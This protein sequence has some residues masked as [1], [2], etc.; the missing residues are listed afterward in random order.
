MGTA[1]LR[2]RLHHWRR[3]DGTRRAEGPGC[4]YCGHGPHGVGPPEDRTH[5]LLQCPA[6]NGPR[7]MLEN[8]LRDAGVVT[9]ATVQVLL[10]GGGGM[11]GGQRATVASALHEYLVTTG[12]FRWRP[13]RGDAPEWVPEEADGSVG[14]GAV[15]GEADGDDDAADDG[16]G[17]VG[18]AGDAPE[19]D[20]GGAD[21]GDLDRRARPY[22]APGAP[23][24]LHG[25]R[26]GCGTAVELGALH[27]VAAVCHPSRAPSCGEPAEGGGAVGGRGD[28][29]GDDAA[30][31]GDGNVVDAAHGDAEV[32]SETAAEPESTDGRNTRPERVGN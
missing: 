21:S 8:R 30:D 14:D 19:R 23:Q 10:G 20:G 11:T 29:D 3:R 4:T 17:V 6:W 18:V 22:G 26:H 24:G 15:G 1:P 7:A 28:A 5:F 25:R 12:R 27:S 16:D 13:L 31:D 32:M 2:A 9:P